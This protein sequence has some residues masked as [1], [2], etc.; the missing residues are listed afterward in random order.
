MLGG[1]GHGD[2]KASKRKLIPIALEALKAAEPGGGGEGKKAELEDSMHMKQRPPGV[3]VGGVGVSVMQN[4]SLSLGSGARML[5]LS[6]VLLSGFSG[7][8]DIALS[9]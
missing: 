3:R 6:L 4:H 2:E 5:E 8:Y 7:S 9:P 1:Q